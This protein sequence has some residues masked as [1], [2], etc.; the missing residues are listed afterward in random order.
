MHVDSVSLP[1]KAALDVCEHV[2]CEHELS[3]HSFVFPIFFINTSP[4]G[5]V[6][7]K[8]IIFPTG[9]FSFLLSHWDALSPS[10]LT[11]PVRTPCTE[12][13]TSRTASF[14]FSFSHRRK[15]LSFLLLRMMFAPGLF[16]LGP[17]VFLLFL[18]Y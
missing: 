15:V 7:F 11:V 13:Y 6:H 14:S 9:L 1:V 5:F 2:S 10:L 3:F 8:H 12:L 16:G 17:I 4:H 18:T